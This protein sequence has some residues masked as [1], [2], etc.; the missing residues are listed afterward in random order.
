MIHPRRIDELPRVAQRALDEIEKATGYKA[1]LI[2]GGLTP[3][4]GGAISTLMYVLCLF[5]LPPPYGSRDLATQLGM[6]L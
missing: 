4:D 1:M 5:F 3:A 2:L 6:P